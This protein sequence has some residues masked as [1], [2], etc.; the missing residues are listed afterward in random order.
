[1]AVRSEE[2][3]FQGDAVVYRFPAIRR[4]RQVRIAVLRR[5]MALGSVGLV[6]VIAGLFASGPEGSA[7]AAPADAPRAVTIHQ[8][9][10]LWGVA[11]RYAPAGMD[12]RDYIDA[13]V[14]RNELTAL[15]DVGTRIRLP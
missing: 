9:Q 11:T 13:I 15:P 6:L 1:V 8:G 10:T 2:L 14:E 12:V 4:R 7:P 5:R 3:S